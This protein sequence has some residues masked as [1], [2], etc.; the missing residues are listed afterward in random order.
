[1]DVR[2]PYMLSSQLWARFSDFSDARAFLA[3]LRKQDITLKVNNREVK[4]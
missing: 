2:A 1:M 4:I 3:A